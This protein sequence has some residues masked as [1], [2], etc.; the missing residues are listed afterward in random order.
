[1]VVE[2]NSDFKIRPMRLNDLGDVAAIHKACFSGSVSLFSTLDAKFIKYFYRQAIEEPDS[3][4]EVLADPVDDRAVGF[5]IGTMKPGFRTRV[6]KRNILKFMWYLIKGLLSNRETWKHVWIR[7]KNIK[8]LLA[9]RPSTEQLD[10]PSAKGPEAMFMPI[11]LLKEA[12][13]D[14]NAV[15]LTRHFTET[16]FQAGAYR[17]SSGIATGNIASIKLFKKVGWNSKK[18]SE[19]RYSIWIDKSNDV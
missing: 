5:V 14:G 13:G 8:K 19:H 1:V 3:Y 7:I 12:R 10:I 17:V 6:L 15:R 11:A 9:D 2:S 18:F 4:A 16:L